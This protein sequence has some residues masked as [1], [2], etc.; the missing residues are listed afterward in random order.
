MNTYLLPK[1]LKGLS[2]SR[3]I[4]MFVFALHITHDVSAVPVIYLPANGFGYNIKGAFLC[5]L[6]EL[7]SVRRYFKISIYNAICICSDEAVLNAYLSI[8]NTATV[9]NGNETIVSGDLNPYNEF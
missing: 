8:F 3:Y 4:S 2:V 5:S 6:R 9:L 1:K 7:K